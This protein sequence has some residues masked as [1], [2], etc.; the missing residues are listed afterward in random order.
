MLKCDVLCYITV[1]NKK[2]HISVRCGKMPENKGFVCLRIVHMGV[3]L[4]I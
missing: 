1:H 4:P 2:A 3:E